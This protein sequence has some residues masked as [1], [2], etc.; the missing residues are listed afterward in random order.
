MVDFAIATGS[1][2]VA[3]YTWMSYGK[4]REE[5]ISDTSKFVEVSVKTSLIRSQWHD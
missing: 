1:A 2:L 3:S 4:L 5:F